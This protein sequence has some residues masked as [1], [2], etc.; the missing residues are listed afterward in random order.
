MGALDTFKSNG[1]TLTNRATTAGLYMAVTG[2][3]FNLISYVSG[4]SEI[5]M[6]TPAV[7][8]LVNLVLLGISVYFIYDG[9]KKHRDLDRN[10]TI[11]VGSG[12]GLGTLAGLISGLISAVWAIVFFQFIA[13]DMIE[14]I[15][16]IS[17][18]QMSERGQSDEQIEQG[19]EMMSFFFSPVFF[20]IMS[21]V[22]SVF[23][24]FLAG[25]ING[26]ILKKE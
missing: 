2:I 16:S 10:R 20:A 6:K 12:I 14:T 26:L 4:L 11:G 19:M 24:G 8:W 21:V 7:N 1:K 23:L 5:A 3:V 9:I 17:A 18:E 13:P 25:L 15:K 22:F